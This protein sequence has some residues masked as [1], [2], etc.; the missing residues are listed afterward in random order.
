MSHRK[1]VSSSVSVREIVDSK[2]SNHGKNVQSSQ[3]QTELQV[4]QKE[5][6]LQQRSNIRIDTNVI[7][8]VAR[9]DRCTGS[10]Q[11]DSPRDLYITFSVLTTVA[12]VVLVTSAHSHAFTLFQWTEFVAAIVV[13]AV[14]NASRR[15]GLI[16]PKEDCA[17]NVH[18]GP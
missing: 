2:C 18:A 12:I 8:K 7:P 14:L 17:L 13:L 10:K 3:E 1:R 5:P 15:H 9:V 4:R 16:F 6:L 11:Q